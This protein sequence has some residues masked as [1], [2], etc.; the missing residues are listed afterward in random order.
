[1][2]S[3]N[4]AR[5]MRFVVSGGEEGE[6]RV[7]ELKTKE[8][9]ANLKEHSQRV[10]DSHLFTNDQYAISC[11]RDRCLFT[12]DLRAERRLTMHREKQGGINQLA[13]ASDQTSVV[14]VG[15]E[16]T[17][18]FWD[19][20]EG[21][22]VGSLDVEEEILAVD[23][24]HNNKYIATG[25]AGLMVKLWD[26]RQMQ[27][28]PIAVGRGHSRDIKSIKFASDDRQAVSVACDHS[29]LVWNIYDA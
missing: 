24:S 10:T 17:I 22:P 4:L 29:V 27:Q 3:L 21:Y 12:W 5:N 14:T 28:G 7:W 9:I 19:L 20:R 11:G 1:V 15:Q 23:M 16:K 8:M 18:V 25:G 13:L 2:T 6:L 26:Q